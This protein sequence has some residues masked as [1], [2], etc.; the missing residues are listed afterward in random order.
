MIE[1]H[2]GVVKMAEMPHPSAPQN[3]AQISLVIRATATQGQ[4]GGR[5]EKE[6]LCCSISSL[7]WNHRHLRR[8]GA[9]GISICMPKLRCGCGNEFGVE[10]Y[11]WG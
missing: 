1:E 8:V 7:N 5:T 11:K 2:R 10:F 3:N 4:T 6:A 9:E